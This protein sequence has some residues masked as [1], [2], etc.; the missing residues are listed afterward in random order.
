[1]RSR[2]DDDKR[3]GK[4][5]PPKTNGHDLRRALD[6]ILYFPQFASLHAARLSNRSAVA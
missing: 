2:K 5:P 4:Y 6:W 3:C 1:M